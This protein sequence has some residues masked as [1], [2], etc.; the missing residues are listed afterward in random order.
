[1][2]GFLGYLAITV[3]LRHT[4]RQNTHSHRINIFVKGACS[5]GIVLVFHVGGALCT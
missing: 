3:L 4:Y 2:P 5:H 1:L